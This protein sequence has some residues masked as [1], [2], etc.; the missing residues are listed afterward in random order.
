MELPDAT[1]KII[2]DTTVDRSRDLP[3]SSAVK[4]HSTYLNVSADVQ[5]HP[6]ES[7]RNNRLYQPRAFR[8]TLQH[9]QPS[10]QY[11]PD[12]ERPKGEYDHSTQCGVK[13]TKAWSSTSTPMPLHLSQ[14]WLYVKKH[15]TIHKYN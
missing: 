10:L 11:A 6:E 8:P 1:E 3:T 5:L 9:T 12:V 13:F 2:S 14:G 15:H 4:R 7:C